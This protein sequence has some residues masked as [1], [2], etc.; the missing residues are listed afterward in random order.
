MLARS[1]LPAAPWTIIAA[2]NKRYARVAVVR[3]VCEA[4]EDGL[5]A[6]GQPVPEPFADD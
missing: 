1:D 3:R 2:E 6:V 4:I 5:R